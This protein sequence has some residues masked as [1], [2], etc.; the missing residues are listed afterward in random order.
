MSSVNIPDISDYKILYFVFHIFRYFPN[1]MKTGGIFS[2]A[3][4]AKYL[5]FKF[6]CV[7]GKRRKKLDGENK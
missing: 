2:I 3:S 5:H 6:H 4:L 7:A 1:R